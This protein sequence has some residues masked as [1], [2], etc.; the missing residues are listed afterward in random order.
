ML[1]RADPFALPGDRATLPSPWYE[2][3]L[4]ALTIDEGTSKS[5]PHLPL[6][7]LS[8]T[9][10]GIGP[11]PYR[12]SALM[13]GKGLWRDVTLVGLG[14]LRAVPKSPRSEAGEGP[15]A[16]GESDGVGLW[17]LVLRQVASRKLAL[18]QLALRQLAVSKLALRQLASRQLALRKLAS[19]QIELRN[20]A[21][22]KLA[23]RQIE[24]RNLALRKLA[25]RQLASR[26]LAL[27][28]VNTWWPV[29]V[30]CD[31]LQSRA[32]GILLFGFSAALLGGSTFLAYTQ[33][34]FTSSAFV[35]AS[36]SWFASVFL[37]AFGRPGWLLSNASTAW[38]RRGVCAAACLGGVLGLVAS[39]VGV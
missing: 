11:L 2:P 23:S 36:A 10:I 24:L 13:R 20:L 34:T 32:L 25:S 22:R 30:R 16:Y 37:L 3:A 14:G 31:W 26:K 6:P 15:K 38:L 18:Q 28:T 33:G 39:T 12:E 5:E 29:F 7:S 1:R 19:R 9:R 27:N 21:L 4:P 35:I 17:Q 8:M